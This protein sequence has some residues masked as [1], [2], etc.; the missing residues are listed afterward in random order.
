MSKRGMAE[1]AEEWNLVLVATCGGVPSEILD[2]LHRAVVACHGW[3]LRQGEISP[4]CADIDF[5]FPRAHSMEVYAVLV[6]LGVNLSLEAHQQ[7]TALCQCTRHARAGARAA[8]A[9]VS[10]TLYTVEGAD[11]FLKDAPRGL[12]EA[13]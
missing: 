3:V 13:A 12:K 11:G 6:A 5:E 1:I 2:P 10:L 9:R 7:L 8:A 4:R